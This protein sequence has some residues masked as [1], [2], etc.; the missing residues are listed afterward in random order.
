MMLGQAC[1]QLGEVEV[2]LDALA[3]AT[4]LSDGNSKPV[5]LRGYGSWSSLI[6]RMTYATSTWRF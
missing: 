1:E 2:A 6:G 4:R 3:T 5:G